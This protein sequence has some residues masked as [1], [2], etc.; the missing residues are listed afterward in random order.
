MKRWDVQHF[1][2]VVDPTEALP[3]PDLGFTTKEDERME[4]LLR[5][6]RAAVARG[7]LD[8]FR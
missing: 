5:E 3:I 2:D 4:E 8:Y 1:L 7:L 6:K